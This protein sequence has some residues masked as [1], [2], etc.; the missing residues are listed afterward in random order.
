MPL[1]VTHSTAADGTFSG[2]GVTAWDASHTLSGTASAAQGGTG[3]AFFAVAGPTAVRT[4]TFPDTSATILT[5]DAAVT[6]AQGGT[7]VANTGFTI[8]LAGNITTT[9]AFNTTFAQG[10]S[11]TL[12]LP[13]SSVTLAATTRATDAFGALTDITTNDATT[14]Q[15]GFLPKLGGGTTNFLRADGTWNSP[16]ASS[17]SASN[18][19]LRAERFY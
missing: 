19:V 18:T 11:V 12:T 16:G 15:H 1:S 2:S 14:A 3:I 13:T 17:E 9:G 4:Y 5:T 8:T 10:A 7:G 6:G